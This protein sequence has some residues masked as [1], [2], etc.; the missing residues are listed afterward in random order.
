MQANPGIG[1]AYAHAG[2]LAAAKAVWADLEEHGILHVLLERAQESEE[3]TGQR[4][5]DSRTLYPISCF[6][7]MFCGKS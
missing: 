2:I 6:R 4:V 5:G 1:A 3:G 7:E